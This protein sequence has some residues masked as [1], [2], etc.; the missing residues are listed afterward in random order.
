MYRCEILSARRLEDSNSVQYQIHTRHG[1][2]PV[3]RNF[4]E[5]R[6]GVSWPSAGVSGAI[7]VVGMPHEPHRNPF[8][9]TLELLAE[10]R[11]DELGLEPFFSAI[12]EDYDVYKAARAYV[13]FSDEACFKPFQT[14]VSERDRG[15]RYA[16]I[17]YRNNPFAGISIVKDYLRNG[18]LQLQ[19][20][21]VRAEAGK[22]EINDIDDDLAKNF[23]L[24]TALKNVV[25]GFAANPTSQ[26]IRLPDSIMPYSTESGWMGG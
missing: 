4:Q 10:Y 13:D 16:D 23:P 26:P 22:M 12:C 1:K 9:D 5:V 18:N 15:L 14:F 19:N 17:C 7:V 8:S 21:E 11:Y 25:S 3:V 6:M 2:P 24:T 20:S